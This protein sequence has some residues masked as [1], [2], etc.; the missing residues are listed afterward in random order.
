MGHTIFIEDAVET[1]NLIEKNL[2]MLTQPSW[3]LLNTDQTPASF[4]I[5]H[6][7]NMFRGNRAAG[8]IRYGFW[9]DTK[10]NSMGPSFDPNVCPENTALG[11]FSDNVA[12]SNGKYGLRIFHNMVPRT[13][14]CSPLVYDPT[15]TTDPYSKNPLITATFTNFLGYKNRE[16]G[17]IAERVGDVRFVNFKVADNGIAGIEVSSTRDTMDG[18]AQINGALVVGHSANA[19]PET[20]SVS[21][22]GI[23]TPRYENF[24]VKNVN[25]YN[26]DNGVQAA[27]GSCSHCFHPASTDSGARTV[28]FSGL[29]F[30]TTVTR[31][32]IYQY[33]YKDIFYDLDGTLTGLGAGT[34]ATPYF[35]HNDQ[36]ECTRK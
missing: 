12:H 2:V 25:F 3:S 11:E 29:Y 5:T 26:F 16:N 28:K 20:L 34:W 31:R 36:P 33:P 35:L 7:D 1:K 10:P 19:D 14:P 22:R 24:Q 30:D 27:L 32:I 21:S 8:S 23:I 17:A 15:N 6:P 18:T 13:Y 4:W 9:F